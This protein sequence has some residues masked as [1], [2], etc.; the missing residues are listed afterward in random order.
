MGI[1]GKN[2][3]DPKPNGF[4]QTVIYGIIQTIRVFQNLQK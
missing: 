4:W 3:L 1:G 2:P